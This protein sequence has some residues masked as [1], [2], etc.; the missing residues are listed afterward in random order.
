M[1]VRRYIRVLP[2]GVYRRPDRPFIWSM[3]RLCAAFGVL[4]FVYCADKVRGS[5]DHCLSTGFAL[6]N[7]IQRLRCSSG[8]TV[9][10]PL[11]LLEFYYPCL[12]CEC[13]CYLGHRL[14]LC[15]NI[16]NLC[17]CS[18]GPLLPLNLKMQSSVRMSTFKPRPRR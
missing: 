5:S 2:G 4:C 3:F 13:Y 1:D 18:E 12:V 10:Y 14:S 15:G 16:C 8:V 6:Q 9:Y 17:L 11:F 7:T